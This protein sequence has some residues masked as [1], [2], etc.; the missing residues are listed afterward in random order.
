VAP[1]A[2]RVE[3]LYGGVWGDV[4]VYGWELHAGHVLCRDLGYKGAL[5]V[6][7]QAQKMFNV[8][9]SIK[10]IDELR[11]YGNESS[12][13]DCNF[14]LETRMATGGFDAGVVCDTGNSTGNPVIFIFG[15]IV[16][17][18]DVPWLLSIF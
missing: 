1:Y 4:D 7:N 12:L 5:T 18:F 17:L 8:E 10:W 14:E 2:G 15:T 6:I 13:T 9:S 3:V 16:F 11:C